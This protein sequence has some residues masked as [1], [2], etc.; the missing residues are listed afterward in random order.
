MKEE[1]KMTN[2]NQE[3]FAGH[4]AASVLVT[5]CNIPETKTI[6]SLGSILHCKVSTISVIAKATIDGFGSTSGGNSNSRHFSL[7]LLNSR[8]SN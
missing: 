3:K 5:S 2:Y 6:S 4:G 1:D 7:N 8:S